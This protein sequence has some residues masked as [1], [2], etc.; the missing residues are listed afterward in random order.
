MSIY[1]T[2]MREMLEQVARCKKLH[3]RSH[4]MPLRYEEE[5]TR[6]RGN[7]RTSVKHV[8]HQN[9]EDESMLQKGEIQ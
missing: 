3:V 1:F 6:T 9:K 2:S 5:M 8:H 7:E 4:R